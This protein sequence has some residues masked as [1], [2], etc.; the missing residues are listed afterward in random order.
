MRYCLNSLWFLLFVTARVIGSEEVSQSIDMSFSV[1][2]EPPVCK[3]NNAD[4]SVDFG[5]FQVSDIVKEQVKKTAEFAFTDCTNVNNVTISFS[6]EHIDKDNNFIKNKSGR[7]YASGVAIGLYDNKGHRIQLKD[8]KNISI[9]YADS[10]NFSVTAEVLKES[11]SVVVTPG[12]I[13]VSVNMNIIY[14]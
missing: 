12:N 5:E 8:K 4:L 3:L 1:N 14:N 7:I 2:I 9:E 6:G 10:F 13:D 11:A